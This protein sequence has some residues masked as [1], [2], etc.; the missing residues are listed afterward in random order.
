[1]TAYLRDAAAG[2]LFNWPDQSRTLFGGDVLLGRYFLPALRDSAS[3]V[4][5]RD[6][7]LSI[8]Q[9]LPMIVNSRACCC[10]SRWWGSI[11]TRM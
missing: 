10:S 6:T 2:T 9:S 3:W 11:S 4:L 8:T 1:M 5:L 7:V